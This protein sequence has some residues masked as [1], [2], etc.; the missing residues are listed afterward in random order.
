MREE[1]K[2]TW[3]FWRDSFEFREIT[4]HGDAQTGELESFVNTVQ[5]YPAGLLALHQKWELLGH[6][7]RRAIAKARRTV[8]GLSAKG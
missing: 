3:L 1:E 6:L 8:A 4:L 2:V 5:P 7:S